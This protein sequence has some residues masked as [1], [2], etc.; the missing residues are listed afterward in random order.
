MTMPFTRLQDLT[1]LVAAIDT[2]M[3]RHDEQGLAMM[4][5]LLPTIHETADAVNSA[6]AEVEGLL[7]EGLRDEAI[8]LHDPEFPALAARL[9]LEDRAGW[10]EVEQ[11][12]AREGIGAPPQIDFD[13]LS[14][15][16]S[17]HSELE[18]LA[19]PLDKLRRMALER[20]P[21]GRRLAL[22]RKLRE[23]D[24][25]KPVWSELIA[26]HEQI[27]AGEL[28][29]AVRQALA[30]RDPEAI[31]ALHD[32]LSA[33]GWAV[34]VPKELVRATHGVDAWLRLREVAAEAESAAAALEAWYGRAA[35][36]PPT[37]EMVEDAR[38]LRQR[39][40]E[41]CEA[42]AGCRAAL[43]ESQTIAGFVRDEGLLSRLDDLPAR[44]QPVLEWLGIQ[45]ARD[46]AGNEFAGACQRLEEHIERLPHQQVEAAWTES[47]KELQANVLRLCRELPDLVYPDQL[48][49]RVEEALAAVQSRGVQRRKILI[50]AVAAGLVALTLLILGAFSCSQRSRRLEADRKTLEKIHTQALAGNFAELPNA[51]AEIKARHPSDEAIA[52]LDEEITAAVSEEFARR[53][54]VGDELSRQAANVETARRKL[55]ERRGAERLEAWPE[56][57]PAGAKAWRAARAVGGDPGHR[58]SAGTHGQPAAFPPED[59]IQA[60]QV[61]KEEEGKIATAEELQKRLEDDF[62]RSATE[63]FHDEL[64]AIRTDA[65]AAI[66][67]KDGKQARTIIGR[68][69]TLRDKAGKDKCDTV[70]VLLG[71][72]VRRRVAREDVE[73][74]QD[75]EPALQA[76]IQ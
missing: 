17:A 61:V 35:L 10:P 43:A 30:A 46:D 34:P 47:V 71:G 53:R 64:T 49:V 7:F 55:S 52:T 72:A 23:L 29:D 75:F 13:T 8:A 14:A 1:K 58:G 3:A 45:D 31:A 4:R 42:A 28:K 44:T 67:A 27:R 6:L 12:F 37:L 39:W 16:E 15:L 2:A 19:R 21:L 59:C 60:R 11:F 73:M 9:N 32:E 41:A 66:A 22:L 33:P 48:R 20:A 26:A 38:H 74:V 65:E 25:T 76:L 18:P 68:L 36:Q 50:G 51:V 56:D 5:D 63:A 40:Q 69:H 70:D 54:K 57:V 24:P 62:R